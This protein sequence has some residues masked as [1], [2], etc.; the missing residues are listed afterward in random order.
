MDN[1]RI[2]C[3]DCAT[4]YVFNSENRGVNVQC[5]VCQGVFQ[6][7]RDG[8]IAVVVSH[9]RR[10][11]PAVSPA[12]LPSMFQLSCPKCGTAYGLPEAYRGNQGECGVCGVTFLIPAVGNVGELLGAEPAKPPAAVAAPSQPAAPRKPYSGTSTMALSRTS[13]IRNTMSPQMKK[14]PGPAAPPAAPAAAPVA[15]VASPAPKPPSGGPG[16]ARPALHRPGNGLHRS[17]TVVPRAGLP[18]GPAAA[19]A[20]SPVAAATA[21]RGVPPAPVSKPLPAWLAHV[22]MNPGEAV[23]EWCPGRE[24]SGVLPA[25]VTFLPILCTVLA[26]TLAGVLGAVVSALLFALVGAGAWGFFVFVCL[27]ALRCRRAVIVTN[28][29]VILVEGENTVAVSTPGPAAN[30]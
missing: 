12:A 9:G 29:R 18:P 24:N 1:L 4:E 25:V 16:L 2:H 19:A 27:P 30:R 15:A 22:Q 6:V 3:P 21:A 26:A 11:A 17:A 13:I 20:P 28:Q 7:P 14:D 5:P 8:D 23:R 10:P